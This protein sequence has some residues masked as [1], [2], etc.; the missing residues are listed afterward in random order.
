MFLHTF[1]QMGSHFTSFLFAVCEPNL[2][3]YLNLGI[4]PTAKDMFSLVIPMAVYKQHQPND[5]RGS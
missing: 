1:E 4:N 2:S 3:L 5:R